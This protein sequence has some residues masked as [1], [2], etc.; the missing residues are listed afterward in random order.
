[1]AIFNKLLLAIDLGPDSEV[2]LNRVARL[3]RDNMDGVHIVHVI[4]NGMYDTFLAGSDWLRD[5]QARQLRDH[6]VMRLNELLRRNQFRIEGDRMFVVCGEP[7]HQIKKLAHDIEADL[8]IVGSH[9]K[10]G[11]WL[12]LPGATTNCVL[13]G[14]DSD[15]MA[16]RV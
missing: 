11:G 14:I 6:A 4:K 13:Q 5:A 3:C 8:V 10:Q 15:V 16:V 2:L 1:M 9:C 7:A 12:N